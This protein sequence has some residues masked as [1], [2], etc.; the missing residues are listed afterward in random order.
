MN[1]TNSEKRKYACTPKPKIRSYQDF[2][3][4]IYGYNH[5]DHSIEIEHSEDNTYKLYDNYYGR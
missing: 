4:E 1:N 3:H 5:A 2:L